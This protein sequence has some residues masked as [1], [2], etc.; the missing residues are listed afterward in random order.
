MPQTSCHI[1]LFSLVKQ[2]GHGGGGVG[3]GGV[4]WGATGGKA[5]FRRPPPMPPMEIKALQFLKWPSTGWLY[6]RLTLVSQYQVCQS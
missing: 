3:W 6:N 4:G 2:L 1:N 5:R